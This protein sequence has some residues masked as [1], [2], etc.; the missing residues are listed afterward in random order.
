VVCK[1][2]GEIGKVGSA[3]SYIIFSNRKIEFFSGKGRGSPIRG[4]RGTK[5]M[6]GCRCMSPKQKWWKN[7][8]GKYIRFQEEDRREK[9]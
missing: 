5:S 8:E 4:R 2:W 3:R 6:T 7:R 1:P 9:T